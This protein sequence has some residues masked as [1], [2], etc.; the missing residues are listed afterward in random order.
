[1]TIMWWRRRPTLAFRRK[2]P[3]PLPSLI[4]DIYG[5]P[6]CN[7]VHMSAP[8]NSGL[9]EGEKRIIGDRCDSA[10]EAAYHS[11]QSIPHSRITMT[12]M[13]DSPTMITSDM[14]AIATT[15]TLSLSSL[16]LLNNINVSSW[17]NIDMIPFFVLWYL[18]ILHWNYL[19]WIARNQR[20]NHCKV[21]FCLVYVTQRGAEKKWN[22][23]FIT[24]M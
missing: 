2:N 19:N 11:M 10:I 21:S 7:N 4:Y 13:L 9:C 1:M 6:S 23:D 18:L 22:T 17:Y 16:P 20:N 24:V 15:S 3:A 12:T 8:V 14:V 5:V